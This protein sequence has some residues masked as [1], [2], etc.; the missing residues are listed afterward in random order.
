VVVQL[1]AE[2]FAALV[3]GTK[4]IRKAAVFYF[5]FNGSSRTELKMVADLVLLFFVCLRGWSWNE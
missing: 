1:W 3:I 2:V 4:H 5:Y